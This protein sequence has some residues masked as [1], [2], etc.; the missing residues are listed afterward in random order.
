MG[1]RRNPTLPRRPDSENPSTLESDKES[2]LH[3]AG[4]YTFDPR[5]GAAASIMLRSEVQPGPLEV[6]E[7]A[8]DDVVEEVISV[9][10]RL[11]KVIHFPVVE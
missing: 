5:P 9:D 8:T 4:P 2:H 1:I 7:V 10:P 11:P 6:V 3:R